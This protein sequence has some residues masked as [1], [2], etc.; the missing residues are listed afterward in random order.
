MEALAELGRRP[1][2]RAGR[3]HRLGRLVVAVP[4]RARGA[5]ARGRTAERRS[6]ER[7]APGGRLRR[8]RRR[9]PGSRRSA[10][11]SGPPAR[12]GRRR[13]RVAQSNAASTASSRLAA[14][15]T[16]DPA[17]GGVAH[18]RAD[19]R[20]VVGH[21]D[22]ERRGGP[23]RD[24]CGRAARSRARGRAR[25]RAARR[26]GPRRRRSAACAGSTLVER[27]SSTNSTAP[28]A[29][30]ER[31]R[32][33]SPPKPC[34]RLGEALV[35]R[36]AGDAQAVEHGAGDR[37]VA[38][39]V[40]PGQSERRRPGGVA[41]DVGR[42]DPAQVRARASPA[43]AR[44]RSSEPSASGQCHAR[45]GAQRELVG[46]VALDRPVPVEMVGRQ[47]GHGDHRGRDVAGRGP[48][49]SM[50]RRSSSR[51]RG[52]ADGSQG[53]CPMLPPARASVAEPGQEV[54]GQRRRRALALRAGDAGDAGRIGLLH[55]QAEP[56]ADGHAGRLELRHLGPVAADA[57]ALDH[58]V[59]A[60]QRVEAPGP[61]AR[62]SSPSRAGERRRVVDQHRRRGPWTAGGGCWPVP[63]RPAPRRRR[64]RQR[65]RTRR[66]AGA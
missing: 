40:R 3:R 13:P 22:D 59:A 21:G 26:G 42:A 31:Q 54:H 35:V 49:S 48:G 53:G 60:E 47:G 66:S 55:E 23:C 46:V 61:V 6:A 56:A 2:R 8:R 10:R 29:P 11:S 57:R 58:H 9:A 7:P 17:V 28:T 24:R 44:S 5:G 16:S 64:T 32:L 15:I 52:S 65:A 50:S 41:L 25:R 20:A 39:V 30:S 4:Q 45:L 51:A 38:R 19:A 62:T 33:G 1:R 34:G 43:C 14:S 63:R 27:L 18:R 12:A 36:R 37:R